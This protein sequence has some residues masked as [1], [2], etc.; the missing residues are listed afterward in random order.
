MLLLPTLL[1]EIVSGGS[2]FA[3]L[4]QFSSRPSEINF[5]VFLAF[6]HLLGGPTYATG[7]GGAPFALVNTT[8]AYSRLQGLFD[9]VVQL[10]YLLYLA[11]YIMLTV[12]VLGPAIKTWRGVDAE[13]AWWRQSQRRLVAIW[14]GLRAEVS[15]RAYL[16]L[17]LWLTLPA[18][19][20]LR[21]NKT[22]QPHYL[23]IV[24]PAVFLAA[25]IAIQRA[26][27]YAPALS[28]WLTRI[29][30]SWHWPEL[31]AAARIAILALLGVLVAGQATQSLLYTAAQAAGQVDNTSY[32]YPLGDLRSADATLAQVQQE[33]GAPAIL[34][35]TPQPYFA[36]AL[37]YMLIRE[38]GDRIGFAGSCLLLP[39][40]TAGPT[41]VVSTQASSPAAMQLAQL[42]GARLI[43]TMPMPGV[44]PFQVYAVQGTATLAGETRL[45]P[46]IYRG[47]GGERLRLEAATLQAPGVLRLRWTVLDG[48]SPGS[49][50]AIFHLQ[51]H[52]T[53]TA[54]ANYAGPGRVRA[55]PL[56]GRTDTAHL[57][58]D[59]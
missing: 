3:L 27:A 16:L 23:F 21:H 14:R 31:P 15:W 8:A 41:L 36:S 5:D 25:G 9:V 32:G 17:W 59:Q 33:T 55:Y 38:H 44:E 6:A 26:V 13:G 34:L 7:Y 1:W 24:Y 30:P 18:L 11:S 40:R 42:A 46:A 29:R 52:T 12:L 37:D 50:P 58:S 22:V 45:T 19:A 20:L 39:A 43:K 53:S 10:L 57:G 47:P 28:R 48:T 35:S 54:G 4:R 2:D 51:L 56:A 49:A